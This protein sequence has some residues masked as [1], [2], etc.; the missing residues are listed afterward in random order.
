VLE[1]GSPP[2]VLF[3][4]LAAAVMPASL[5]PAVGELLALK[6]AA[7]EMGEGDRIPELDAHAA[8]CLAEFGPRAQALPIRPTPDWAGLNKVFFDL[9]D[10]QCVDI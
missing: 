8:H 9:L 10:R 2:P 7:S 5:R 3:G 6:V 4:D 1:R